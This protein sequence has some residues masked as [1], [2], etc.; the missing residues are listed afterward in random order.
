M[1]TRPAVGRVKVDGMLTCTQLAAVCARLA[2]PRAKAQ[3]AEAAARAAAEAEAKERAE[4][5]AAKRAEEEEA[6]RVAR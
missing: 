1:C 6:S 3:A 5:E 2:P 4:A